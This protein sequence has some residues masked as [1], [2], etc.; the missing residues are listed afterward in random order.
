MISGGAVSF[1]HKF[2]TTCKSPALKCSQVYDLA[3]VAGAPELQSSVSLT[4][5]LTSLAANPPQGHINSFN[6]ELPQYAQG[7][8]AATNIANNVA[9][10]CVY[11]PEKQLYRA[12]Y[13]KYWN[14][15]KI[16]ED[17]IERA[18]F[19]VVAAAIQ[20]WVKTRFLTGVFVFIAKTFLRWR[21]N[22]QTQ[23]TTAQSESVR[24]VHLREHTEGIKTFICCVF[25][26]GLVG[27]S[28]SGCFASF[29]GCLFG[30]FA[31]LFSHFMSFIWHESFQT[32]SINSECV[33]WLWTRRPV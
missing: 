13:L 26:I 9:Q 20:I 27:L 10:T 7:R 22:L 23:T 15:S 33:Q 4:L 24:D 16:N 28:V 12:L 5:D 3:Q 11:G 1:W 25:F 6:L 2:R 30:H 21:T 32:T 19:D 8:E 29:C 31:S 18:D 14:K 17:Q